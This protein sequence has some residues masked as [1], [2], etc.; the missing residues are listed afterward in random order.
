MIFWLRLLSLQRSL[1]TEK[2]NLTREK[3]SSDPA[4]SFGARA[5]SVRL[6]MRL[7]MM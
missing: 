3:R 6:N 5:A 4:L 7:N 2:H 1:G